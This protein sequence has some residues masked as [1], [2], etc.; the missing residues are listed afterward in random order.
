MS[1]HVLHLEALAFGLLAI[2]FSLFE[3][4]FGL[5]PSEGPRHLLHRIA[6]AGWSALGHGGLRAL[7]LSVLVLQ[8]G[9]IR[10]G[11][12]GVALVVTDFGLY[13]GHRALHHKWLWRGH[14]L[15]H[16]I[17]HLGWLSGFRGSLVHA[18]V[19]V[20]VQVGV[21][22]L[23]TLNTGELLFAFVLAA[24]LQFWAHANV[25]W[26]LGLLRFV[27]I[28]PAGHR[29]HHA[30]EARHWGR[31]FGEVSMVWDHLFGTFTDPRVDPRGPVG[32][33]GGQRPE[34]RD[35]IGV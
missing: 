30:S 14:R 5:F 24:V 13:V 15:H 33:G 22:A 7:L 6:A 10:W 35:W 20:L 3:A 32:L 17:E 27:L 23:F 12:L 2:V 31:N 29:F 9:S 25:G 11:R 4:C 19:H 16:S 1:P 28:T 26:D 18:S 34:L 21:F 8:G